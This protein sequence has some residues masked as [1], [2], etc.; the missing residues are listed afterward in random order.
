[1]IIEINQDLF[2]ANNTQAEVNRKKLSEN[3]ILMFDLVGSP[4]SGKTMLLEKTIEAL[5]DKYS[6]AV[7]EGDVNT[8]RDAQRLERFDIP[9]ISVNTA[10]ACH[11]ESV[12]I[13]N[14]LNRI[15]LEKTDII[16]VENVGNLVCPAEFDLGE[17][18]KIAVISTPEGD[19][20]PMKYPL[21]FR[22]AKAILLN[23]TDLMEYLDFSYEAFEKD[24]MNLNS[25]D[26]I[27]KLSAKTGDGLDKWINFIIGNLPGLS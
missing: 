18:G 26:S 22:E 4:G 1:M 12:I 17:N 20:K 14:A 8:T 23:K 3:K 21:I 25:R 7:I 15:D 10:G 19:D 6:I 5:K 27:I 2:E 9:I 24:V 13:D 16:F 11:I